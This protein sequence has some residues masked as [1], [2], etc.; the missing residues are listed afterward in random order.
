MAFDLVGLLAGHHHSRRLGNDSRMLAWF[1]SGKQ[2]GLARNRKKGRRSESPPIKKKVAVRGFR[3]EGVV[4][5][6][7]VMSSC[8]LSGNKVS[9]GRR[10]ADAADAAARLGP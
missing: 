2:C 8:W 9:F 5:W 10:N 6:I 7:S 4:G 1:L 3:V